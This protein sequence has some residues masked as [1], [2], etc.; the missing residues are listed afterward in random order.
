MSTLGP[1]DYWAIEYGYKPLDP[2]PGRRLNWPESPRARTSLCWPSPRTR[3]TSKASIPLVN[4]R[5]LGSDPGLRRAPREAGARAVGARPVQAPEGWREPQHPAPQPHPGLWHPVW[6]SGHGRQVH[7]W[8]RDQPRPRRQPRANFT[9]VSAEKQRAALKLLTTELLSSRSFQF[10]PGVPGQPGHRPLRN[11]DFSS[12]EYSLSR[13]VLNVQRT[14]LEHVYSD[15]VAAR[16][17]DNGN[18]QAGGRVQPWPARSLRG[19]AKRRLERAGQGQDIDL[20]RRNLQ[21]EQLKALVSTLTRP[22]A[23][24]RPT[25]AA[26]SVKTPAACWLLRAS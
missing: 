17:L 5:D 21:R 26:C 1:Y 19:A 18:K 7:R 22:A 15:A 13:S 2:G 6:R 4:T 12:T 24:T 14:V 10:K 11:D 20:L 9:P 23:S 16:L 3:P 25:P 8:R